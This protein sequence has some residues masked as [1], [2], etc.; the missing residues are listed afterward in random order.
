MIPIIDAVTRLAGTWLEGRVAKT[1]AKAKAEAT[2][3][4]KQAESAA[5]WEA[6]M[7]RNSGQ[8]WKDEWLT[9]LFSVPLVMCFIPSMVPYV[10]DGFVVLETMPDFYQYTLSVIVAASFGVRSVIGVMN[11]KKKKN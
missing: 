6:A 8:S 10:R 3:I 7:A 2:V 9:L 4:I 5:D 1:K 11:K